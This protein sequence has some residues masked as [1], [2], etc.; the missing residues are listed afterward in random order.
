MPALSARV[1]TFGQAKPTSKR[2]ALWFFVWV[3]R[4]V[5][6][7]LYSVERPVSP[8]SSVIFAFVQLGHGL[9]HKKRGG[10]DAPPCETGYLMSFIEADG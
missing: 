6:I 10:R 2:V 8:I 1:D 3:K 5:R 9:P 4:K 7:T